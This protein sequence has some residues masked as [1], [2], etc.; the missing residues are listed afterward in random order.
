MSQRPSLAY[1][2]VRMRGCKSRLL[3]RAD[4][5]PL[6]TA[7]DAETMHRV[8]SA[9][10]LDDPMQRLL[11]VYRTATRGYPDG[12]PLFRALLQL[13]ELEDVKTLWRKGGK[14]SD[15]AAPFREIAA[16][17]ARAHGSD[18]AAAELAF[19][20]WASRRLLDEAHRL[21]RSETITRKLIENVVRE[22]DAEIVRRGAKWYGLTSVQGH[23]DDVI[24]IRRERLRLC[25]R[26]FVGSPFL[27]APAIAVILLA[28]EEMRAVR[29]LIERQ[30]DESLDAPLLR[31]TAGSQI[32]A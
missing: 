22:R 29:A 31:A 9:L 16:V 1:A 21:P 4:A 17:I 30:G 5:L 24:A 3:T 25:R 12:L 13:H 20:R 15:V 6:F 18:I 23:A 10:E 27:L 28:E 7:S 2:H 26:A 8:V 19:D 32:G 11:R 14:P